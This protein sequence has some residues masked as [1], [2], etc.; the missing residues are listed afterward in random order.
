MRV[1]L[2]TV[3]GETLSS[4]SHP[5]MLQF[6]SE[7]IRLLWTFLKIAPLVA[8]YVS[9][10]QTLNVK[11]KGFTEGDVPTGCLKVTIEQRAEYRPG[12]GIPELYDASIILESE[13]PLFRRLLWYWKRTIFIWITIMLFMMMLFWTLVCCNRIIMPR[14]GQR[15]RPRD[16]AISSSSTQNNPPARSDNGGVSRVLPLGAVIGMAS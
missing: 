10:S 2:L 7:P 12:A 8:G 3:K 9:E 11:F 1:E 16:G 5:C 15:P 13:L 14:P 4:S 6:K